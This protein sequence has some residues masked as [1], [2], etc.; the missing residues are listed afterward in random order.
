MKSV[1]VFASLLFVSPVFAAESLRVEDCK[2]FGID[3][4][5]ATD[6]RSFGNGSMNV[7]STD[8]VEPAGA[9]V[10]LAVVVHRGDRLEDME[11][12]CRHVS[13]LS[14]VDLKTASSSYDPKTN[15]LN[16]QLAGRKMK[17]DGDYG[18]VTVYVEIDR[19]ADE[20]RL[21]KAVVR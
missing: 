3:L 2:T 21:V 8:T 20:S 9:P 17:A 6:M 14:S 7:F 1:F 18:P 12:I 16:L 13:G 11:S 10:G 4:T 15:V 19:K 5:S